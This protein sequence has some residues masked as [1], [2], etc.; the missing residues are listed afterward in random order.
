MPIEFSL[1]YNN[2]NFEIT[3]IR[4]NAD[5]DSLD[6]YAPAHDDEE[7][8]GWEETYLYAE[9]RWYAPE[10]SSWFVKKNTKATE[11]EY[12]WFMENTIRISGPR[13]IKEDTAAISYT[14]DPAVL[15][16]RKTAL[17]THKIAI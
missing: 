4:I 14:F 16:Q 11:A 8:D 13:K 10:L 1:Q 7:L 5:N 9:G 3:K 15:A 6:L 12:N 2:E 17:N